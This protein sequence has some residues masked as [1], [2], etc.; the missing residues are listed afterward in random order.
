MTDHKF[1]LTY[2]VGSFISYEWFYSEEEL[3][4]FIKFNEIDEVFDAIEIPS[5]RDLDINNKKT[6]NQ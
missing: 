1:L 3:R 4:D 6:P 2:R 5:V